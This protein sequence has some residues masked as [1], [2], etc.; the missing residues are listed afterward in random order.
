MESRQEVLS[1]GAWRR[2]AAAA[3]AAGAAV[4]RQN[5]LIDVGCDKMYSL[6]TLQR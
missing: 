2:C 3:A 4:A 5:T 6:D 1:L